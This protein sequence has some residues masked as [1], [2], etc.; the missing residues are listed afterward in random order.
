[1]MKALY[2]V[3]LVALTL[4]LSLAKY[5]KTPSNIIGKQYII[6]DPYSDATWGRASFT[7]NKLT[8]KGCNTHWTKYA[9]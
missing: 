5:D 3:F 9:M 8:F 2:V 7:K 6:H 1:M 4:Q